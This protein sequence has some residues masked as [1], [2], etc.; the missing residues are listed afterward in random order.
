MN[1]ILKQNIPFEKTIC[2]ISFINYICLLSIF[3]LNL[4]YIYYIYNKSNSVNY[5][6]LRQSDYSVFI[7]NLYDVHKRF[8]D[9]KKEIINKR[10]Q[11]QKD[12]GTLDNYGYDYKQ[13][14]GLDITLS[15]QNNESNEFEY[16]LKNKILFDEDNECNSIDN[17]A[18]CSKLDE[19]QKLKKN[20][21]KIT[22]KINKIK[23][24]DDIIN[25]NNDNN[26]T[27]DERKLVIAKF[28]FLCFSF[29]KKEEKLSE[30]KIQKEK[31]YKELDE[32]YQDSKSKTYD[33][34]AGC[35]FITFINLKEKKIFLESF[36]HSFIKNVV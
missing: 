30:L 11:S 12:G 9:I 14:I 24:D 29:C 25:F 5:K 17:I 28:N 21:E 26:L 19:F 33:Y 31:I 18:L 34:F 15:N 13:K 22:P 6:Y 20:M 7:Y 2:N 16:F 23:F 27:G 8:L 10:L 35:S 4:I 36:S 32:L 1:L 3:V